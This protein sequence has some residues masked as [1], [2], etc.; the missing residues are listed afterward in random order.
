MM[1]LLLSMILC[2]FL[3]TSVQASP[4]PVVVDTTQQEVDLSPLD[5]VAVWQDGRLKSFQ[6]FARSLMQHVTG[7]NGLM[8][9]SSEM[10]NG[11]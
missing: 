5:K 9:R 2:I 8:H 10:I 4:P 6:S 11:W 3:H 7:P 1:R